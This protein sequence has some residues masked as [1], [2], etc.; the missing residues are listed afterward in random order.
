MFSYKLPGWLLHVRIW[1][2][3]GIFAYTLTLS[4]FESLIAL[5]AL[6]LL[7]AILPQPL[8]RQRF[9]TQGGLLVLLSA[10]WLIP[11]EIDY[12]EVIKEATVKTLI[13]WSGWYLA[14]LIVAAALIYYFRRL[15]EG[16]NSFLDRLTI[17]LYVYMPLSF[18]SLT[19]VIIRGLVV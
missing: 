15:E 19:I 6:V 7:A 1:D 18:L 10:G 13:Y 3:A 12:L 8:F 17:L 14:S 2:I 16:L 11:A 4:L 9:A 5:S